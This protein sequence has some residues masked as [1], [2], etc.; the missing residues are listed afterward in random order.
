MPPL[1]QQC[2]FSGC[3]PGGALLGGTWSVSNVAS[4]L[5]SFDEYFFDPAT[6][7]LTVFYNASATAEGAAWAPPPP[8]LVLM[9]PQLE[10]FFHLGAGAVD[11]VIDGLGFRDQRQAL[12]DPWTVPSGGDWGLRPAGA[13]TFEGAANCTLSNA[14]F[15]R[16]DANAVYL[17]GRNRGI[18]ILDSEFAWLGM[19]AVASLGMTE[20]DDA[21]GGNQPYGTLL[22]GLVAR[23][24]ALYEK[25]SSAYFLGRTP[26]SRVEASIFYNG[27]R[28]MINLN[29]ALGGGNNFTSSLIFNTCRE[30]GD[31]GV[32][33]QVAC[34]DGCLRAGGGFAQS[35]LCLTVPFFRL[36]LRR[37]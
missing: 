32:R 22:S 1:S 16:T 19:N 3:G 34:N 15:L 11:I 17:G 35:C 14:Y 12:L 2:S 4:E 24:L 6:D 29:D 30:S 37:P 9:A 10:V 23:E 18:S 21:T 31:H 33:S 26:L 20:Q 8:T 5:D 36:L 27:P 28:A 13:I 25:Q 7:E